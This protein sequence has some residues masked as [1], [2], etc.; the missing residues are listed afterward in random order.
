[1][2]MFTSV[3]AVDRTASYAS[4]DQTIVSSIAST[5]TPECALDSLRHCLVVVPTYN[6]ASNIEHLI[7]SI[8]MQ[9]PQ[10]DVLVVDDN[11]PDGTG[12]R[13]AA[14]AARTNRVQ[15]LSRPCKSGLGR[16]YIAGFQEGLRQNYAY[17]CQMDADFSHNPQYLPLLLLTTEYDA[18]VTLGSRNICGGCTENW[19]WYRKILSRGG[20]IY[21]RILLHIPIRDC[22]GGFKCLRADVLR[23]IDL[24]TIRSN[25]YAFQVEMNYRCHQLGYMLQ[26]IPIVFQNR[27]IGDSKISLRIVWEALCVVW[28]LQRRAVY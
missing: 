20:S 28:Q 7:S 9:G 27:I 22:T 25:G 1:M 13:V 12:V 24:D 16:A 2:T 5:D 11:S 26:E 6:E 8:L 17:I 19:S 21:A 14:L 4:L 18:D 15:L 10:F 3:H 23:N